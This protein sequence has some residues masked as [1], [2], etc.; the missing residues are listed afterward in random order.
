[1]FQTGIRIEEAKVV[2]KDGFWKHWSL[3]IRRFA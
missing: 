3:D 1:M 2:L